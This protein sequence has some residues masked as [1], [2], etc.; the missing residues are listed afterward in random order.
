MAKHD[1]WWLKLARAEQCLK[2]FTFLTE[3]YVATNP[4]RVVK[5]LEGQGKRARTVHRVEID[6]PDVELLLP[7]IVGDVLFNIRSALDHVIVASVNPRKFRKNARFPVLTKNIFE[8]DASG[9]YAKRHADARGAW[10]TATQGLSS[11]ALTIV[12]AAQP[13]NDP[14]P[15]PLGLGA[16]NH[17][18]AIL[19]ILQNAD[20]HRELVV[21]GAHLWTHRTL[22]YGNDGTLLGEINTEPPPAGQDHHLL[23][24]GAE[25]G[26]DVIP[27]FDPMTMHV[28]I[29]GTVEVLVGRGT[30]TS[31]KYRLVTFTDIMQFVR[32]RVA[33]LEKL[34]T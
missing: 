9:Q 13:Y 5:R 18:L 21:V 30:D 27:E 3:Q 33:A 16:K 19:N 14:N 25:L 34:L 4:H 24:D 31:P 6:Q 10:N 7:C 8:R 26:L 20:K 28:K 32:R 15:D 22:L 2:E 29:E 23:E 1:S 12:E 11:A 17:V